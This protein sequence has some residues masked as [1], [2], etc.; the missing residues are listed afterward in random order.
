[1]SKKD[2]LIL[3]RD[4]LFD[5]YFWLWF[6]VMWY[7]CKNIMELFLKQLITCHIFH[8]LGKNIRYCHEEPRKRKGFSSHCTTI[9]QHSALHLGTCKYLD[10]I[11]SRLEIA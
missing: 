10:L 5:F 1:M 11:V 2:T 7:S 8:I 3:G 9:L 6:F 4:N